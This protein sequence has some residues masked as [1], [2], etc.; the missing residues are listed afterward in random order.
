MTA[1]AQLTPSDLQQF[2]G[3]ENYYKHNL[4][5]NFIY[6]DGVRYFARNAGNGA[7]WFL[8]IAATTI[9]MVH[10]IQR[11]EFL[12]VKIISTGK[13]CKIIVTDGSEQE[14]LTK[15]IGFTDCPEGTWSFFMQYDGEKSVMLLT[16]EY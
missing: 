6:T 7:Y 4:N 12:S 10:K 9:F 3:T 5:S 1:K 11:E 16:S 13:S 8:D 14:L 15:S 2:Y